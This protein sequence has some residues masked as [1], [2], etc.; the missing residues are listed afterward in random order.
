MTREELKR[1]VEYVNYNIKEYITTDCY[2]TN[3]AIQKG[4]FDEQEFIDD[5]VVELDKQL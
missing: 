4:Y 1:I 2:L 5:G 3:N